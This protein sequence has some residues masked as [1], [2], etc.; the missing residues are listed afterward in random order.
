MNPVSYHTKVP[1]IILDDSSFAEYREDTDDANV[2]AVNIIWNSV[3]SERTNRQY[4]PFLN[5]DKEIILK[6]NGK[7]IPVSGFAESLPVLREELT[8]YSLTLVISESYYTSLGFNL[9][10][11]ETIYTV[12]LTDKPFRK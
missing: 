2:I 10:A 9:T 4:I 7:D 1:I 11:D 3:H 8:Q 5:T 12:K 6:I